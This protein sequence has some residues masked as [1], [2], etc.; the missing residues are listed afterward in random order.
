MIELT[1]SKLNVLRYLAEHP[2]K[3]S[4]TAVA[5][6]LGYTAPS[7]LQTQVP[8]LEELGLITCTRLRQF[9]MLE[10]SARGLE[11]LNQRAEGA[12]E[13]P[14]VTPATAVLHPKFSQVL[15]L[16]RAHISRQGIEPTVGSLAASIGLNNVGIALRLEVMC[17][18]KLVKRHTFGNRS[19]VTLYGAEWSDRARAGEVINSTGKRR[20]PLPDDDG[21]ASAKIAAEPPV[22]PTKPAAKPG[23]QWKGRTVDPGTPLTRA[24]LAPIFE[25][26]GELVARLEAVEARP[27][28]TA[29]VTLA[30]GGNSRLEALHW[31][32]QIH[33]TSLGPQDFIAK[34]NAEITRLM[35]QPEHLRRQA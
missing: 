21:D 11:R 35:P 30:R 28:A 26:L 16:I 9:K 3:H 32:K 15:D 2:G 13:E 19:F 18:R 22:Q 10:I 31:V 1:E 24:D 20:G 6:A 27:I 4:L 14:A 23:Q 25:R 17:A 7:G 5:G 8:A 33:S 12:A 34:L 29:P